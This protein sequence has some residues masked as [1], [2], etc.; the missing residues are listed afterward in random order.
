M[1]LFKNLLETLKTEIKNEMISAIKQAVDVCRKDSVNCEKQYLTRKEAA[2]YLKMSI[3][4]LDKC[5]HLGLITS[6]RV[7]ASI[8]YLLSDLDESMLRRKFNSNGNGN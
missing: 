6:F 1:D 7:G 2:A 4:T 8:R 3:N 5:T